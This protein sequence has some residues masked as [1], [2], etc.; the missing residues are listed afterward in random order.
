MSSFMRAPSGGPRRWRPGTSLGWWAVAVAAA[1]VMCLVTFPLL[2]VNYRET[3]PI[4]DSWVMP[5]LLTAVFNTAFVLSV[6]AVW[7]IAR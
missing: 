5:T 2:T 3:Y 4:T 6:L 7:R 1:A